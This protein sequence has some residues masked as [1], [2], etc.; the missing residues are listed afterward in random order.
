M[1]PLEDTNMMEVFDIDSETRMA[2]DG[3]TEPP[4]GYRDPDISIAIRELKSPNHRNASIAAEF[5]FERSH[6]EHE[7]SSWNKDQIRNEGGIPILCHLLKSPSW[8]VRY[9]ACSAL[10]ELAFRNEKNC[11]A[12]V[13]NSWALQSLVEMLSTTYTTMQEDA[14]LVINNC[15]AFCE[16]ACLVMIRHPGLV[17]ALKA[18][19]T[20]G[21]FGAK[22][23]SVGAINC[24]TRCDSAKKLLNDL[25]IVEEALI[26][27]I[28]EAGYGEKY[29]ARVCRASMA[30]AN[31]TGSCYEPLTTIS[32]YHTVAAMVEILGYSL[33]GKSWAGINF[34]P[35]SVLYPLRSLA[36]NPK[37]QSELIQCGLIERIA[38]TMNSWR[39][40]DHRSRQVLLLAIDIANVLFEAPEYQEVFFSS[41]I[42]SATKLT[43]SGRRDEGA[44]CIALAENLLAKLS[45]FPVA[46]WMGLHHRLGTNSQFQLLD[47]YVLGI[48]L[49][50]S[51]TGYK[52]N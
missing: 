49:E 52:C 47:E 6:T 1:I 50:Y 37:H 38:E 21:L 13:E 19:V 28:Q 9:H 10:S 23:V 39:L 48:I 44:E 36:Y 45:K 5:L 30:I 31:L 20:D 3:S 29:N 27:A 43:A 17:Q 33:E 2:V 40:E 35:Y 12:I 34:A 32:H 8:H 41:G 22:N 46:V 4:E 14:A 51:F 18:L 42:F 24:L 16:E 25:K 15:A 26:P 11:K 7:R